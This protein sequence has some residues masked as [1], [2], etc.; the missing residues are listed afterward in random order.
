MPLSDYAEHRIEFGLGA[1]GDTGDVWDTALW[2]EGR[3]SS[4]EI[5]WSDMTDLCE[6]FRCRGGK[7]A[8]LKRYRTGLSSI[9]MDNTSGVFVP[10]AGVDPPGF[11]KLRPGR[12]VRILGRDKSG[13][14]P[15]SSTPIPD[16]TTWTDQT[17]RE[18]T[19]HGS[20]LTLEDPGS[21]SVAWKP[22]WYGRI[23]TIDNTHLHGNLKA[24]V[25]CTDVFADFAVDN[26]VAQAEQGAGELSSARV[27][28]IL[29]HFGWPLDQRLIDTGINTMQAT[30]MARSMYEL[31]L[32]TSDS[33][34]GDL[35]IDP[36]GNVVFHRQD[37]LAA[38]A[39]IKWTLGGLVGLPVFRVTPQWSIQRVVNEAHF[40]RS[41]GDE[42]VVFDAASQATYSRR[43]TT[44]L[45]LVNDND[46]D[47][48]DLAARTVNALKRDKFVTTS[49][50]VRVQDNETANFASRV[51]YGDEITITVDTI[52]GWSSTYLAH[53]IGVEHEVSPETW[54][55]TITLSDALIRNEYGPYSREEFSEAFHLGGEATL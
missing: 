34:G 28:R 32:I 16:G 24:L 33:E 23:D 38:G 48:Q 8:F 12:W 19:A 18:W 39:G 41:G 5:Q 2:D 35:F 52:H 10:D 1:A 29:D 54:D 47:V 14:V 17:G 11:L 15:P 50:T 45:D 9:V 22:L 46:T 4:S 51:A 53:C 30:T 21:P 49:A 43:T 55:V 42:Q 37:W 25:Q 44:R 31:L 26:D 6:S 20:G 36:A 40:S 3:W 13:V 7:R 27:T